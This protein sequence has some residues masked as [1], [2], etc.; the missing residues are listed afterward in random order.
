[1]FACATSLLLPLAS[2]LAGGQA[3]SPADTL[4]GENEIQINLALVDISQIDERNQTIELDFGTRVRW[5]EP[6]LVDP[7]APPF[8][9]FS[10]DKL[11]NPNIIIFNARDL[12]EKLES[13]AR[14]TPQG[15]AI[16]RQRYQGT[17]SAPM[18]LGDFPFDE[19]TFSIE[20][21]PLNQDGR[22]VELLGFQNFNTDGGTLPGWTFDPPKMGSR[23]L[24]TFDG[25]RELTVVS[26]SYTG[27]RIQTFFFWKLFLPLTLI[28]FMA[29]AVF[30]LDPTVLASQ[31]AV[32]TSSVF[33][34]IAYNFALS[35]M[36]PRT[37]YLS[38]A[39]YFVIGCTI[40]VFSAL[41]VT[42]LTGI[43]ARAERHVALARR[44]DYISRGIYPIGFLAVCY[45]AFVMQ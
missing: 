38:R 1:M 43:L 41:Y 26:V 9:T 18:E 11:D 45:L 17:L 32:A 34:L 31:I 13:V 33:T 37:S 16:Y 20:L 42:V 10:L 7:D 3:A 36:L 22:T 30:W 5:M 27:K 39:D 28:V 6:S 19:Q 25:K 2:C 35:H 24:N 8:R 12:D 23:H 14:V 29:Y 44:I 4:P 40:L 15:E 21:I